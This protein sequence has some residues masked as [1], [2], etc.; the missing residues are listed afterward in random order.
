M[1]SKTIKFINPSSLTTSPRKGEISK[2]K[3]VSKF[4]KTLKPRK[5]PRNKKEIFI[6]SFESYN[7]TEKFIY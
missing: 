2:I 6:V 5:S 3:V 4:I 1:Y 7:K